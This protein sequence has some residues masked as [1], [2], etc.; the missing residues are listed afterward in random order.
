MTVVDKF[1]DVLQEDKNDLLVH[2]L[3]EIPL[4]IQLFEACTISIFY[5]S[6]SELKSAVSFVGKVV[7][8]MYLILHVSDLLASTGWQPIKLQNFISCSLRLLREDEFLHITDSLV[9]GQ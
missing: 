8:H 9:C 1:L 2:A 6:T 3:C 4:C 5:Q 7:M